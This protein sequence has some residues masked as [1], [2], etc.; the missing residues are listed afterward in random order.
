MHQCSIMA[1]TT[2][3]I[4]LIIFSFPF[5]CIMALKLDIDQLFVSD[6]LVLATFAP[7]TNNL[8]KNDKL[9]ANVKFRL[10]PLLFLVP[11]S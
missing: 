9:I 1:S 4:T 5:K 8:I 6:A 10:V 3:Q 11:I 2:T 7:Q